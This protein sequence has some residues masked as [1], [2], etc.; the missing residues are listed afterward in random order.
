M[1][2][3][4]HPKG[5]AGGFGSHGSTNGTSPL[6]LVA[7]LTGD[8]APGLHGRTA[9]EWND[10]GDYVVTSQIS[11]YPG[12]GDGFNRFRGVAPGCSWAGAK[13]FDNATGAVRATEIGAA[14][15]ELVNIRVQNNI[16]VLN[17]SLGFGGNPG[18]VT[19]IRQKVN[20]AVNNGIVAVNSA[21]NDGGRPK[22]LALAKLMIRAG[23]P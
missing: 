19:S 22:A 12:S 8:P 17:L 6:T 4:S 1:H 23:R 14:L 11:N 10:F 13:V 20:T 7:T 3:A 9:G 21:G 5:S 2:L 18:I 15:D 16:K